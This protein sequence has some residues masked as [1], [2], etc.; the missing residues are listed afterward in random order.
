MLGKIFKNTVYVKIR[1]NTFD[2]RHIENARSYSV[3][4]RTPFT[5]DRLLVGDFVQAEETLKI[6]LKKL[7][8]DQLF[9]VSPMM[10]LHPLEHIEGGLSHVETRVFNELATVAGA[11]KAVIWI[12]HSLSDR[13]VIEK[14]Q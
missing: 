9:A 4:A 10:V 13:E 1:K 14:L 3:S 7:Y 6:G 11:R 5:T 2:L 8:A 12:G